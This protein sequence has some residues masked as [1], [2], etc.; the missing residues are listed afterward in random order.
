MH[1]Y[2]LTFSGNMYAGPCTYTATK[3]CENDDEMN[4]EARN[5]K[6][7]D[8][9]TVDVLTLGLSRRPIFYVGQ[10]VEVKGLYGLAFLM[11]W[12]KGVVVGIESGPGLEA[13]KATP[14]TPL[15]KLGEWEEYYVFD[16]ARPITAF[17]EVRSAYSGMTYRELLAK[18][19]ELRLDILPPL[20][21]S[22]ICD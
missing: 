4:K 5:L 14:A 9:S 16:E 7:T 1:S 2:T 12:R 3:Q 20:P 21:E 11:Q 13:S 17:K 6:C 8:W 18:Q 15:V 22:I 10:R 19:E